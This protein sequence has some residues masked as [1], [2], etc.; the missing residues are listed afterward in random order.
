MNF[1]PQVQLSSAFSTE[2]ATEK[3][4]TENAKGTSVT[5]LYGTSA[6]GMSVGTNQPSASDYIPVN[7]STRTV[8]LKHTYENKYSNEL[9]YEG[10]TPLHLATRKGDI[11]FVNTLLEAKYSYIYVNN[12][13]DETPLDLAIKENNIL[14]V[15]ALLTVDPIHQLKKHNNKNG[16]TPLHYAISKGRSECASVLIGV[17]DGSLNLTNKDGNTPVHLAIQHEQTECASI[18]IGV[19]NKNI[20][21]NLKND[22]GNAPLHLATIKSNE[23]I[24]NR[25][26]NVAGV[27]INLKN[28]AGNTP[29]HFA[30]IKREMNILMAL[31]NADT[32]KIDLKNDDDDTPIILAKRIGSEE[33]LDALQARL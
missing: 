21:L 19:E 31:L 26:L 18:L 27:D 23:V 13:N 8:A 6:E 32:I 20:K 17:K 7:L 30:V 3:S 10:N 28:D 1:N 22:A 12:D 33:V 4:S 14:I 29:L 25:L 24:V 16:N 15:E 11:E 2:G 9:D 5:S